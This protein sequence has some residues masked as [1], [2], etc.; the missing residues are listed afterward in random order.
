MNESRKGSTGFFGVITNPQS[1][2]NIVYLLLAFPLGT[3][4]FVFLV[5]GLSL[6]LG[7]S[8]TVLGLPLLA[9]VLGGSW[10]LCRFEQSLASA[11]LK[12]T[13]PISSHRPEA[14]GLWS[15]IKALFKD[16]ATWTGTLYLLLKFPLGVAAFTIVVTLISVALALIAAPVLFMYADLDLFIWYVDTLPEAFALTLI[17]VIWLFVSLH[18]INAMAY[19]LSRMARALLSKPMSGKNH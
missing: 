1:Y 2:L 18:L 9:L 19:G 13:F 11:M 10:A 16:R 15:R 17:G 4:Y 6:G 8:I 14:K 12:E 5:T 3:F 7:L